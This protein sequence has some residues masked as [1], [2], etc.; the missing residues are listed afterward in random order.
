MTEIPIAAN[1]QFMHNYEVAL[2]NAARKKGTAEELD[3]LRKIKFSELVNR[4]NQSSIAKAEHWARDS[5]EYRQ[6]SAQ[7]MNAKTAFHIAEAKAR[8][9][10]TRIDIWRTRNATERAKMNLT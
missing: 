6:A 4:S 9:M 3:E 1:D 8:G 5:D 10:G 2:D 7:A